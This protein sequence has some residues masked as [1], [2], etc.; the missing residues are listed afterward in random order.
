M[1]NE[2]SELDAAL[3]AVRKALA[4]DSFFKGIP[5]VVGDAWDLSRKLQM[6]A[7]AAG[8]LGVTVEAPELVNTHPN[9]PGPLFGEATIRVRAIENPNYTAA[10]AETGRGALALAE[11]AARTLHHA[12]VPFV[13]KTLVAKRL[14]R[15]DDP[16][17]R[18]WAVELATGGISLKTI[19]PQ[20]EP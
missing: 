4:A 14:F 20:Q 2:L 18:V 8:G 13:G 15:A 5:V 10:P 9:V 19:N 1:T 7:A 16:E 11:R 17:K 3:E 6:D 12:R